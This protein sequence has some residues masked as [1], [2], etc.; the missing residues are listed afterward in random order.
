MEVFSDA[1]NSDSQVT[2]DFLLMEK[3]R[4]PAMMIIK[5]MPEKVFLQKNMYLSFSDFVEHEMK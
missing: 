4:I 2:E 1:I 5:M 3:I